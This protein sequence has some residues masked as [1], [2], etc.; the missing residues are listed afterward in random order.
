MSFTTFTAGTTIRSADINANFAAIA[1]GSEVNNNVWT[2]YTAT[3]YKSDGTTPIDS[4]TQECNYNKIGKQVTVS[5]YYYDTEDP[6]GDVIKV[7]LPVAAKSRTHDR[8]IGVGYQ[9]VID[10][11][12]LCYGY[13]GNAETA[14]ATIRKADNSAWN[15]ASNNTIMITLKYEAA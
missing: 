14:K 15:S 5:V 6:G 2:A 9:G 3:F 8:L 12:S 11:G 10:A 7:S 4:P 1:D 13:I